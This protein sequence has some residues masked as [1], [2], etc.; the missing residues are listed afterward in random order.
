[1]AGTRLIIQATI[2]IQIAVL[3]SI[4]LWYGLCD[5]RDVFCRPLIDQGGRAALEQIRLQDIANIPVIPIK[6][7]VPENDHDSWFKVW[8]G[9]RGDSFEVVV[10]EDARVKICDDPILSYDYDIGVYIC[11]SSYE[12][13]KDT[14]ASTV[15]YTKGTGAN[16]QFQ[17]TDFGRLVSSVVPFRRVKQILRKK[18]IFTLQ[19]EDSST[20][21]W[22]VWTRAVQQW[23]DTQRVMD[24]PFWRKSVTINHIFGGTLSDQ[25]KH[26]TFAD[27]TSTYYVSDK[28]MDQSFQYDPSVYEL[29][30]YVPTKVPLSAGK[31]ETA[32]GRGR[33]YGESKLV[34]FPQDL[35]MSNNET[36]HYLVANYALSAYFEFVRSFVLG[37]SAQ[38][39]DFFPRWLVDLYMQRVLRET[40]RAV[41][42]KA[43]TLQANMLESGYDISIT[44]E[45][46][47][48]FKSAL[49]KIDHAV[50]LL[51]ATIKSR[52]QQS[53][54]DALV[55]L[56]EALDILTEVEQDPT[57][58][59]PL[60]FPM[61]QTT[62]V[63]APLL[64]PLLI[65]MVA[66]LRREYK[67]FISHG[68]KDKIN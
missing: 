29:L 25:A 49:K 32:L 42:A 57:L 40:Y 66:G 21:D 52:S 1:M 22:L 67:R 16:R 51:F 10:N 62:A 63:F 60:V 34:A 53:A 33:F 24:L 65:P 26:I 36:D 38:E 50:V 55:L 17:F 14:L 35:P 64:F 61:D 54:G 44:V 6:V 37:Q 13:A 4:A 3:T 56:E 8:D 15:V 23:M 31:P 20:A 48:K 30:L 59:P 45:I 46:V 11:P 47:E 2:V 18:L 19:I 7:L 58:V 5:N 68:S 28:V 43:I 41:I 9:Y 27:N 12:Y 39:L